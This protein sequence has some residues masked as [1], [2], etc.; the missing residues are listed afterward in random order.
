MKLKL[1]KLAALALAGCMV[2]SMTA[3]AEEKTP[4]PAISEGKTVIVGLQGDPASFNPTAAPDDWG[5]YVAENLF[6]RLV[7]LNSSGEALPDLAESWDIS[8]DGLTVTF[9][10]HEDAVWSDGE[11]VT[12]AD[13]KW[14]FDKIIEEQAYL[15]SYLGSVE[16]IEAVDDATVVFHMITPDAALLSNISFLGSFILPEHVYEGQ[17]WLTCEAA[18]TSPVTSGPFTLED[19][20]QGVSVT[21]AAN[22]N[23]YGGAPA[24]EKL[25]YQIIPDGNTAVQ[26][27]N[28]GELDILGIMAPASQIE[29]LENDPSNV[30]VRNSNFGRYYYG[31]NV[32]SEALSDVRV[33]EAITKAVN[34]EEIVEKAFGASG[35][36]AEGYYTPA[37]EWAYNEDAVIPD[38]DQEGAVELLEEAG[39]TKD[40]D[41]NY[42]TLSMAT[43]NLDPF[44]NIAQIM[45]ANLAEIGVKLEINTMEAAAFME[46]GADESAYDL[47]AMGG[48][49]GPDPSMFYHRIG[50]DGMMN[51]SHY[52]NEEVDAMFEEAAALTD[53]EERGELY[54]KIQEICAED[55]IFVPLSEDIGINVYK[56][57][58]TG[59]PYDTSISKAAQTEMTYVMFTEEPQY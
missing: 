18:T 52:S 14:T 29:D 41:G 22:E 43:F 36:L 15:V 28:N 5:Y 57:Y 48:Q 11:P 32:K 4:D 26:A 19:Y 25:I 2:C 50:T 9:H 47:F 16:S 23:Y 30:V 39:L 59:L 45:Q 55:F 13:V 17:D 35:Q 31:F 34:R 3:F 7:K 40:S 6:S 20:Q 10:L 56:S 27:Y 44:T 21:L 51:F 42:L 37:V 58:L 46:I 53:Q 12:S 24:Y 33:R 1:K 49:V 8:E 54:K 38:F